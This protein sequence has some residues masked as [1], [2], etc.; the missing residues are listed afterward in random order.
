MLTF[1]FQNWG[2]AERDGLP[3]IYLK[4]A[5]NVNRNEK[6]LDYYSKLVLDDSWSVP[7]GL[8]SCPFQKDMFY[9][10]QYVK[11]ITKVDQVKSF[12]LCVTALLFKADCPQ[13]P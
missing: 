13:Y 6:N 10:R 1:Y 3:L 11:L 8:V 5:R 4:L 12:Q 9:V 2:P 7:G